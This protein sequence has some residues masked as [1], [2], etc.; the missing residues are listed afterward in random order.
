MLAESVSWSPTGGF[1]SP[2]AER[3]DRDP[4]YTAGVREMVVARDLP[5]EKLSPSAKKARRI[6][7]IQA[8]SP[9]AVLAILTQ[10]AGRDRTRWALT[11]NV[12]VE[13]DQNGRGPGRIVGV[14]RDP[15]GFGVEV[16]YSQRGT[17][18]IC[19]TLFGKVHTGATLTKRLIE[20]IA[21][22]E[23]QPPP[24]CDE[25]KRQR[26]RKPGYETAIHCSNPCCRALFRWEV[27][28][29]EDG[30]FQAHCP[31][32]DHVGT[33]SLEGGRGFRLK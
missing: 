4:C 24:H 9:G 22:A 28:G 13:T 11:V 8:A 7:Q 12:K 1:S 6:R 27:S 25:R 17:H 3:Q 19:P 15:T 29:V 16:R 26:E 32:C 2:T 20:A 5:I 18:R 31:L 23:D 14:K 33:Y 21:Q 30:C 10:W